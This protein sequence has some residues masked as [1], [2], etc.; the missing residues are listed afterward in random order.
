MFDATAGV[1]RR[2]VE[3][4]VFFIDIEME[5]RYTGTTPAGRVVKGRLEVVDGISY[6]VPPVADDDNEVWY[7]VHTNT[8][9]KEN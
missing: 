2:I 7:M 6:I 1:P 3:P 4:A 9:R 5:E 8:V